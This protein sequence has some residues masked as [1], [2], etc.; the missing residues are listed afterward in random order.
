MLTR[1]Q[2]DTGNHGVKRLADGKVIVDIHRRKKTRTPQLISHAE[3]TDDDEYEVDAIVGCRHKNG[4]K[5]Y[6]IKWKGYS[7]KN[8]SWE[9]QSNLNKDAL[10]EAKAYC[11]VR[12]TSKL[13]RV[14]HTNG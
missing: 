8:N 13:K 11:R 9:P 12:K 1:R 10:E 7:K 14:E 6:L 3:S 5:E 2:D 4:R